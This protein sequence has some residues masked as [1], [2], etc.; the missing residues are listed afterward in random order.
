MENFAALLTGFR[1]QKKVRIA[2]VQPTD[3]ATLKAVFHPD[4]RE[5]IEPCLIGEANL[6]QAALQELG[7]TAEVLYAENDEAAASVGV[8]LIHKGGADCLMKGHIQTRAFLQAIVNKETGIVAGGLLCHA[9]LN[10]IPAYHKLL[11]TMDGGMVL[12][13]TKEQKATMIRQGVTILQK[14][15]V[16][17]PKVGLLAAA[18]VMNPKVPAS[19]EA[20]ELKAELEGETDFLIEG[21]ISLDLALSKEIAAIKHYDSPVAGDADLLIGPDIVTMNVLGKSLTVLAQGRM[22]GIITGAKVPIIMTSRGSD[23]KEK[24]YSILLAMYCSE[25]G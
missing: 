16:S 12:H 5:F 13:P 6:I 25:K 8:E 2:V 4:L 11:L 3:T 17:R 24:L 23:E 20:F 9:A 22:A 15:G 19:L 21:P 10:E 14:I 18:E 1:P 7:E